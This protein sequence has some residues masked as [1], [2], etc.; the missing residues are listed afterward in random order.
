[1]T[2]GAEWSREVYEN[3]VSSRCWWCTIYDAGWDGCPGLSTDDELRQIVEMEQRIGSVPEWAQQ[4]VGRAINYLPMCGHYLFPLVYQEAVRA[5]GSQ[6]APDFVHGC[7]AVERQRKKQMMDYVFCLDAWL[8][9][10]EPEVAAGELAA[11]GHRR[12]WRSVCA[13]LWNVLGERTE[14]KELLVT[15]L[16]HSQ[17]RKI[18]ECVWDDDLASDF[19]RDQFLGSYSE[20]VMGDGYISRRIPMFDESSSPR[21]RDL[22]AKLAETC[23]DWE[24]FRYTIEYGWLCAPKAFRFLERLLWAIGRERRVI[25]T[26]DNPLED[27][28]RVPGF[29]RH[30]DTYP[31]KAAAAAWWRAFC[32]GLRGWWRGQPGD[33]DVA[34]EVNESLGEVTPIKQWLV[35][36]LV[37]K[38]ELPEGRAVV[39]RHAYDVH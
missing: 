5:I 36:L 19:G 15:R 23:P 10:A 26:Y 33:G 35:R 29:L 2:E 38:L 31:E 12:D 21:I 11:L 6:T 34:G 7:W 20:G 17:R 27:G 28:D 25:H 39:P 4:I 32:A 3:S 22:E 13:D 16:V 1:M 24:W 37:R 14:L 18:K 9:G 30:E 8:A